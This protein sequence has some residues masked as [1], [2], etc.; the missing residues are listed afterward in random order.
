M[1][2]FSVPLDRIE[3]LVVTARGLNAQVP[4]TDPDEGSNPTDDEAVGVLQGEDGGAVGE[5]LDAALD[6]LNEEQL[7][8][9]LALMWVGRGD[10]DEEQWEEAREEA[11]L[12]ER[13]VRAKTELTE[14]PLLADHLEAGLEAL[15]IEAEG[16]DVERR[17]TP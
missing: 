12:P 11:R 3:Y 15:G 5:A 9:L 10:Y 17:A 6:D 4:A 7:S 14:E 8:D 2:A 1:A 13:R 16:T